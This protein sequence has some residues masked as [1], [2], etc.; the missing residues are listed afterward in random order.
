MFECFKMLGIDQGTNL[1]QVLKSIQKAHPDKTPLDK[2]SQQKANEICQ[3]I[4]H[5]RNIFQ[6]MFENSSV[7]MSADKSEEK[8]SGMLRTVKKKTSGDLG[9]IMGMDGDQVLEKMMD[10]ILMKVKVM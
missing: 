9:E 4:T 2:V 10:V 7:D 6:E 3:M 1:T 5:A 8:K